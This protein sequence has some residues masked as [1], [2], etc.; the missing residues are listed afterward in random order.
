MQVSAQSFE[1]GASLI[2]KTTKMAPLYD[3]L[4]SLG[5]LTF[6]LAVILLILSWITVSLRIW[7]RFGIT[8][9]PGWDDAAMVFTL[10]LY[11]CY[12][13]FILVIVVSARKLQG[14]TLEQVKQSLL[15]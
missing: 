8:K 9:T 7:V 5:D 12:I 6:L 3:E 15:V 10:C 13:A 14:F 11:T 2:S 1:Q 4:K